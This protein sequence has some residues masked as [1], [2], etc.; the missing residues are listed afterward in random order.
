MFED[1]VTRMFNA[2]QS[3][4]EAQRNNMCSY[5]TQHFDTWLTRFASTPEG[6][7][8]EFETFSNIDC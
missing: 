1:E 4:T 6:M 3:M 8:A 2:I 7:A 5:L